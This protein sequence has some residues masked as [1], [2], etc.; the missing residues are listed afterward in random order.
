MEG[1]RYKSVCAVRAAVYHYDNA[2]SLWRAVDAGLSRVD[3]FAETDRLSGLTMHRIVGVADKLGEV[4]INSPIFPG[5]R[6]QQPSKVFLCWSD[7]IATYGLNFPNDREAAAFASAFD[8]A[9]GAPVAP[10]SPGSQRVTVTTSSSAIADTVDSIIGSP[11]AETPANIISSLSVISPPC[12]EGAVPHLSIISA[13]ELTAKQKAKMDKR[14]SYSPFSSTGYVQNPSPLSQSQNVRPRKT[15]HTSG[16]TSTGD[17]PTIPAADSFV[18][19]KT[20][21]A[22][23]QT[24]PRKASGSAQSLDPAIRAEIDATVRK[25]VEAI[26]NELLTSLANNPQ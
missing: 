11:R 16:V 3:I 2:R 23:M 21:L 19:P 4:N 12:R 5:V 25:E 10:S 17:L 7:D 14:K 8:S 18:E 6:L 9:L 1:A 22:S 26:R 13:D 15:I 20:P 24:R